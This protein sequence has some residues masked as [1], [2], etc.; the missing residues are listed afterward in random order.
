MQEFAYTKRAMGTDISLSFVTPT[1]ELANNIATVV[2]TAL[3][4][5]EATFSRFLPTSELSILNRLGTLVVS[6]QFARV[7]DRAVSLTHVTEGVFNPLLQISRQGYQNSY[8]TSDTTPQ[9]TQTEPY[10]HDIRDLRFDPQ[11]RQVTLAHTQQLDFGGILKG[12]L[13]QTLADRVVQEYPTCTGLIINIGGDLATRGYDEAGD[14][15]TFLVWNPITNIEVPLTL[16]DT[17][18]ATSGTYARQWQ[19]DSGPRHHILARDGLHNIDSPAVSA[20]VI[21]PDGGAAEAYTK[22]CLAIYPLPP[23]ALPP[24]LYYHLILD[25]GSHHTNQP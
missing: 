22:V 17:S 9:P 21:Y 5:A 25:D 13:A 23:D 3:A 11:T 8:I 24:Q 2:W 20:S 18:L 1:E 10:N 12:Y 6:E 16:T 19:S 15:F 7:L 14:P 4:E